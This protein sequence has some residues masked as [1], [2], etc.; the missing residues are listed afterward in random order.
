MKHLSIS[1]K[2]EFLGA[3]DSVESLIFKTSQGFISWSLLQVL[4]ND[5]DLRSY[6]ILS[7]YVYFKGT[8]KWDFRRH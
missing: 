6:K 2:L 3:V 5:P 4:Q 7:D 8:I 1:A